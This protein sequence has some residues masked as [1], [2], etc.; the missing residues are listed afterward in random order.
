MASRCSRSIRFSAAPWVDLVFG[1]R[2]MAWDL[3]SDHNLDK[4]DF[5]GFGGGAIFQF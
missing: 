2:H 5:S 4:L 3:K 1:Y